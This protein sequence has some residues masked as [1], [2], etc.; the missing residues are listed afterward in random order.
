M[1]EQVQFIRRTRLDD[2]RG[3]FLKVINGSEN[4]LPER[5]GEIY[6]TTT[7]PGA[8]RGN[9]YHVQTAEWFT[10]I[11]GAA[12]LVLSDST[13][14]QRQTHYISADEPVTVYMPAGVGHAIKNPDDS[15]TT[16]I[17]IMYADHLYDPDDTVPLKLL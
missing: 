16:L 1:L 11:Q 12:E 15:D 4:H 8:V 3:W 13:G 14:E 9:H 2:T 10:V 17:F 6:V 7:Q 5:T